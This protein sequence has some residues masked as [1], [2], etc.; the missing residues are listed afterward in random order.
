[1]LIDLL[2]IALAFSGIIRNRHSGFIHQLLASVGFFAGLFLGRLL[3]HA[4][5][6]LAHTPLSRAVV[7]IVTILGLAL[8]G[9]TVG[10]YAG[11]KVKYHWRDKRYNHIDNFFG[12]G[13]AVASVLFTVWL[14]AAIFLTLPANRLQT[15]IK[16]S[17]IISAL[18]QLLP[19]V[20]RLIS[21]I[22]HL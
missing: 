5:I 20:P 22:G 19:P 3:E 7:T 16:S 14:A 21:D 18:N 10:E 4:T 11:L 2:I 12:M 9:L 8:V 17:R 1:M 15:E 13:L 6:H